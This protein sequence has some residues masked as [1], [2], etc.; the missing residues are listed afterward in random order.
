MRK[1]FAGLAIFVSLTAF[2]ASIQV[3]DLNKEIKNL[4]ASIQDENTQA[5]IAFSDIKTDENR[6]LNF[7]VSGFLAKQSPTNFISI[8]VNPL[9]YNFGD[10]TAPQVEFVGALVTDLSKL[11]SQE[12]FNEIV[13]DVE[14]TI[15][16]LA[17]QFAAEFKEALTIDAKVTEKNQDSAGDFTNVKGHIDLALDLTRLPEEVK[18]EDVPVTAVRVEVDLTFKVGVNLAVQATMNPN[19]KGFKDGNKGMKEY[20]DKLLAQDPKVMSDLKR[21]IDQANSF[22][23]DIANRQ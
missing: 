8:A 3:D 14:Q 9:S 11:I 16:E 21:Y 22:A 4:L 1:L 19:Y 13:P 2:A 15:K 17:D 20:L 23:D 10:G 5:E 6:T 18:A 7:S 12:Q